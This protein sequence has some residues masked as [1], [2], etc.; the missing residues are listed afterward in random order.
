MTQFSHKQGI[1]KAEAERVVRS[2]TLAVL[3]FSI[4]IEILLMLFD[5]HFCTITSEMDVTSVF[6]LYTSENCLIVAYMSTF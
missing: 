2:S 1:K 5:R 6:F 3:L 4:Y